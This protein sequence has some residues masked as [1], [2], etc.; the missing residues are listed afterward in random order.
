VSSPLS[1][2]NKINPSTGGNHMPDLR[3]LAGQQTETAHELA[4]ET[5]E[6]PALKGTMAAVLLLGAFIAASWIGVF[7]LFVVRN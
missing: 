6:E 5:K 2:Y 4:K 7:I 3:P 1:F